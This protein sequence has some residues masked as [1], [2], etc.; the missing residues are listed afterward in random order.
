MWGNL[1]QFPVKLCFK[2]ARSYSL[3]KFNAKSWGLIL[4]L[5]KRQMAFFGVF[6][7]YSFTCVQ[8]YFLDQFK[9]P[10]YKKTGLDSCGNQSK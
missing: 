5:S 6:F 1:V 2:S 8:V 4:S 10:Q 9:C 7:H 3:I